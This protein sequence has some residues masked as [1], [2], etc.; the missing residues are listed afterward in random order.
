VAAAANEFMSKETK[1]HSLVNNAGVM[2]TEF[3]ISKDG[4]EAQWQT[5]YLSHW[6]L[7]YLLLPVPLRTAKSGQPGNV[8][9]VDVT[10]TGH[11]CAPKVAIDFENLN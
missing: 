10:S 7:T 3:E 4:Y 1:L 11:A 5:N 6:L 8:R 9:I 2:A